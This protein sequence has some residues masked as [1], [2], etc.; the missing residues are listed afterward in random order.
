MYSTKDT[1]FG[2]PNAYPRDI[3]SRVKEEAFVK[4]RIA[5]HKDHK[6]ILGWYLNDELGVSWMQV[7]LTV[8]KI[9]TL[10]DHCIS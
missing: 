3:T 6:A 8:F 2:G 7:S 9:I 1:Y 5:E 4:A 10:L